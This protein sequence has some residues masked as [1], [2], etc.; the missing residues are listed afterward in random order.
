MFQLHLQTNA[1]TKYKINDASKSSMIFYSGI[2]GSVALIENTNR[3]CNYI[4]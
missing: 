1:A 4:I 3:N 2:C